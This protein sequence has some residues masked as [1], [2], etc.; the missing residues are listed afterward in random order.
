MSTRGSE[1]MVS[2]FINGGRCECLMIIVVN[3]ESLREF[4]FDG[5]L[6]L[7]SNWLVFCC[8]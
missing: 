1:T 8:S 3:S 6:G 2:M 4:L 7:K 5:V